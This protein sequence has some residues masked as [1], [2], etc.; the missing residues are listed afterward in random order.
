MK[1]VQLDKLGSVTKRLGLDRNAVLGP[2]IPATE[3]TIVAGRIL[4]AKSRYN[5]LEDPHGRMVPLYPGDVVAGALGRR[6]A[7]FGYS[8]V[9]PAKVEVGDRL[10]LLNLGGVIGTGAE[11]SP[12]HGPPFELEVLGAVLDFPHLERR[13][14]RPACVRTAALAARPL[15]PTTPPVVALAGTCMDSGKTT[16]AAALIGG[17]VRSGLTV[18]A[19][20]LTGVSLQRDVLQMADAGA[21][22]IASFTDFGV[23]TTSG[24]NVLGAAH[25]LVAHL[26]EA[27]PDAIVLELGDGLLGPYGVAELL[28]DPALAEVW[29]VLVLCAQDPVGAHGAKTLL[30]ERYGLAVDVLS[31]RVTDTPVGRAFAEDVLG[32]PP[33]NAF[34]DPAALGEVTLAA[35]ERKGLLAVTS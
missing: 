34:S 25:S 27:E 10:Q 13:V 3:G 11:R 35:L 30:A 4:N 17:L 12:T 24:T 5:S 8:G 15:P 21:S 19:G 2:E 23:V 14:G 28:G 16:A 20:K 9:V 7:L 26:A 6:E 29:S 33:A 31:G 22:E 1:R 32:V 18:A